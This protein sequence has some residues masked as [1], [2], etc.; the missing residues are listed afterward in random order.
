MRLTSLFLLIFFIEVKAQDA[1]MNSSSRP[2]NSI[3]LNFGEGS[4]IALV[5]ERLKILDGKSFLASKIGIGYN[6][7]FQLCLF[8]PCSTSPNKF[9]TIPFSISA[10]VG[11][12]KSYLEIGICHLFVF[13]KTDRPSVF[14]I[15]GGYRFQVLHSNKFNFRV[16]LNFPLGGYNDIEL[17]FLPIGFSTGLCF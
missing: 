17:I 4:S 10:N 14:S 11:K 2:L 13:G 16:Y 6:K 1:G 8:G 12:L 5:Y 3:A 7:E 15:L 9:A